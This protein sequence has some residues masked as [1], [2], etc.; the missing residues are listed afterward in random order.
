MTYLICSAATTLHCVFPTITTPRPRG[1]LPPA[2]STCAVMVPEDAIV[3]ATAPAP[4]I[5]GSTGCNV[6]CEGAPTAPTYISTTIKKV[7]PPR[8]LP[9]SLSCL[10]RT[11]NDLL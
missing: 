8:T 11:Q 9:S 10:P 7:Q 4:W 3:V 5:S 6:P 1:L 2:T